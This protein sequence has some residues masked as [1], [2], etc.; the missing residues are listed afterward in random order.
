MPTE[1]RPNGDQEKPAP[2]EPARRSKPPPLPTTEE[3]PSQEDDPPRRVPKPDR[4]WGFL[5]ESLR[6]IPRAAR[7]WAGAAVRT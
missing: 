4:E 3:Q 6:L 7:A 2:E 5:T 1:D